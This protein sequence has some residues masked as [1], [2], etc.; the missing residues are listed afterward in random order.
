MLGQ[1]LLLALASVP[2]GLVGRGFG[3]QALVAELLRLGGVV[4]LELW[5]PQLLLAGFA[6]TV[7]P[8]A[9]F[10][11]YVLQGAAITSFSPRCRSERSAHSRRILDL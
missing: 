11:H 10:G 2:L 8:L 3:G 4:S 5:Q 9:F 1:L 6:L 7:L